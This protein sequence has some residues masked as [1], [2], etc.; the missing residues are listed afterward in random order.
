MGP[1]AERRISEGGGNSALLIALSIQ[2]SS[3]TSPVKGSVEAWEDVIAG[4]QNLSVALRSC[5][6][7]YCDRDESGPMTAGSRL[8]VLADLLD[9][10]GR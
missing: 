6:L 10:A 8:R 9:L 2:G 3:G 1:P 5:Q 7:R 4:K